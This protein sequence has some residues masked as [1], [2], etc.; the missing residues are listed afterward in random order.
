MLSLKPAT[1]YGSQ[2]SFGS[3]LIHRSGGEGRRTL[4]PNHS[5]HEC[6]YWASWCRY[7]NQASATFGHNMSMKTGPARSPSMPAKL[8]SCAGRG[9]LAGSDSWE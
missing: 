3:N 2:A 8:P 4:V 7:G 1:G 6:I 9:S 5:Q